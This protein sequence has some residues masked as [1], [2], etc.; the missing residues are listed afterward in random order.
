[1]ESNSY[2]KSLQEDY[3]A[4]MKNLEEDT[5]SSMGIVS[6]EPVVKEDNVRNVV[7]G[8]KAGDGVHQDKKDD[9]STFWDTDTQV[10][11]NLNLG[12]S[13]SAPAPKSSFAEVVTEKPVQKSMF[14]TLLNDERV[15]SADV[16]LPLDT[17]TVAQQ[18]YANSLIGFFVGKNVAFTLVQNY[19]TNT[20]SKLGFQ[21]VIKDEDGFFFFKFDSLNGLEQVRILQKSQ[22][23]WL[24]PDK[25]G[26]G[27][28]RAPKKP[29]ESYQKSRVVNSSQQKVNP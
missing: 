23:K 25:H 22:E 6:G 21:T 29:G 18:R 13:N 2:L 9:D 17:L 8:S 10:Y 5:L 3:A 12:N 27:N 26:N 1:M 16:V 24:K 20:W 19:V 11:G 4:R 7:S 14:R 15:E 28:G